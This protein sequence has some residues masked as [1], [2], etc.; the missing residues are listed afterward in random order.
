[1]ISVQHALLS[2]PQT[3]PQLALLTEAWG[4]VF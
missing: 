4:F 3:F 1:M 2:I